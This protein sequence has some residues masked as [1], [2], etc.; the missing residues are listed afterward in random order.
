MNLGKNNVTSNRTSSRKS[1]RRRKK[2]G[3]VVVRSILV[4]L[5]VLIAGVLAAFTLYARKLIQELP[6][7]STINIS[8]TGYSTTVY[9]SDG[10]AIQKLAASGAN[11]EYVTLGQIPKDV[12]NAFIAIEDARF[13]EHNG[14]D[15]RGIL[16]AG[17]TGLT[18][19]GR[20][21]GA[22]TITQ[23]LLKNNYFS[24]WTSEK[25]FRDSLERKIQEQYL[26]VQLEKITSKQTI[27]ENYLNTINLGQNT[28]GV[29]AASQRYFNKNVGELNLSEAAVIAAITQNP[30]RY[31]PIS[32]PDQNAVRR[33]QVLKDMLDQ[34]LI[35]KSQYEEALNDNVYERIQNANNAASD[36]SVNSYFVDALTDEVIDDLVSK[37]GYTETQAYQKLYAGGLK[38][39]STQ[40]T[41]FQ[42]IAENE[43]NNQD[44]YGFQPKVS[45]S[46]ALTVTK[47]DGTFENYSSQTLLNYFRQTKDPNYSINYN[48]Q[49]EA[50]ASIDEYKAAILK[51]GD[52]IAPG[53]ESVTFTLQPQAAATI[54]DQKTGK[55]LALVGGRGDKNASKTLNR[56]VNITRQPGSTFKI[57]AVYAPALDAGGKTLA[58]VEDNAP[59]TY[60]SSDK[61][62]RN[63]NGR[64][65][66]FTTF[67]EAIKNS[68]NV[69]AV[70]ALTEIG[71]S[72]GYQYVQDFGIS[73]LTSGDNNQTLAIGGITKGVTTLELCGA[74]ATIAD[75]GLYHKPT[76][77]TKIEDNDG[78]VILNNE[79]TQSAE[80]TR[81]IKDS[82]A[83]LLTSAMQDVMTS[84]TG[85]RAN[86][87]TITVAGKTGTTNDSRDTLMAG[88]SPYYTL[89]VWGGYDD[90]TPQSTTTYSKNIWRNIMKQIN[91]GLTDPGFPMPSDIVQASVCSESGKLPVDGVCNADPRGDKTI[92]EYFAKDTV[93]TETCDHHIKVKI[94]LA[95]GLPAGPYCPAE[96]VEEKVFVTG[97]SQG[98]EESQYLIDDA[99]LQKTCNVHTQP[100]ITVPDINITT[101]GQAGTGEASSGAS[102]TS[103]GAGTTSGGAASGGGTNPTK[104]STAA[105]SSEKSTAG[106][107]ATRTE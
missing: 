21:Q 75:S 92:N 9:D 103:S 35:K 22:S 59:T 57:L 5:L 63:S 43:I 99:T 95:S 81:V 68:I 3:V 4:F 66:G 25:T 67:R 87:S 58:S 61:Q 45:F 83:W 31:N 49:E 107:T 20:M 17:F 97:G 76:F 60:A 62:I 40:N 29:Q 16:R 19:G 78:N 2:A 91:D 41:K 71:T 50:Q 106:N 48:S 46:Y 14:V 69:V 64:Y 36:D 80:G 56:A 33:K 70:K 74:Y 28:L 15:I 44:N 101:E 26:A 100:T 38:I 89:T 96:Q 85:V 102:G 51:D 7:V 90:N 53:N 79:S 30:T 105:G 27:L 54:I 93:P 47:A 24:T 32:N 18:Q 94:C 104:S 12:Q 34:G 23:Q 8:P 13:Y 11:R 37:L 82:T 1:L 72:L 55:V 77:Y 88:F 86:P 10:N 42:E 52:T 73:T 84:G 6:D 98:T 39:Y 65:T